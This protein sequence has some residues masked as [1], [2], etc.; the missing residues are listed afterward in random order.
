M[1][2][3]SEPKQEFHTIIAEEL[4]DLCE[5]LVALTVQRL[6]PMAFMQGELTEAMSL[7]LILVPPHQ[8]KSSTNT[9]RTRKA[10]LQIFLILENQTKIM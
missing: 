9:A 8:P 10:S 7:S 5:M 2:R 4:A 6:D 3:A 1:I